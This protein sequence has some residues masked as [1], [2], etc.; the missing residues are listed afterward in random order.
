[1]KYKINK[2]V[3]EEVEIS[4]PCY[5][6]DGLHYF[7]VF[8]ETKC[9]NIM[10]YFGNA[11]IQMQGLACAFESD[12]KEI[13]KQEFDAKYEGVLDKLNAMKEL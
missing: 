2:T 12:T 9:L 8:S 3:E 6:S 5:R 7:K 4:L 10:M 11:H 1:M 13:T